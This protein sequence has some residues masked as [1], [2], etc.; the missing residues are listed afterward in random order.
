MI[1]AFILRIQAIQSLLPD[2]NWADD[3]NTGVT[4]EDGVIP[5]TEEEI[6]AEMTRLQA[7]HDA[8]EYARNR[9]AEYPPIGDQLDAL[10]HAGIFPSEMAATIQAV[11]D[12]YPKV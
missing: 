4:C 10:F 6:Q 11:K 2:V 12:K 7:E 1:P 8:Q 9:L 5:P 3:E